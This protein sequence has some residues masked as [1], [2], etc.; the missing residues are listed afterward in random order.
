MKIRHFPE[1]DILYIAL[2]ERDS[3]SSQAIND[4][5]IV[6]VDAQGR[7]V[8]VTLEHDSEISD[9]SAIETLLPIPPALQ[10]T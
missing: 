8:G 6:D 3:S 1:P 9:S 5:L 2:A 10:P 7:P 4:N